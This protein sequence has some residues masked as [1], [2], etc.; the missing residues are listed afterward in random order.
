MNNLKK[1]LLTL[2]LLF[3]FR[4]SPHSLDTTLTGTIASRVITYTPIFGEYDYANGFIEFD[5]GFTCTSDPT[6]YL[7]T[8]IPK[9]GVNASASGTIDLSHGALRLTNDLHLHGNYGIVGSYDHPYGDPGIGFNVKG[10][11]YLGGNTLYLDS[12]FTFT[13][14][15]LC[16]AENGTID[17]Q[18]NQVYLNGGKLQLE[19]S[20]RDQNNPLYLTLK[21]MTIYGAVY[22]NFIQ[23]EPDPYIT[24]GH[25]VLTLENVTFI[26]PTQQNPLTYDNFLQFDP[27]AL[28]ISGDVKFFGDH[29]VVRLALSGGYPYYGGINIMHNSN[30]YAGPSIYLSQYRPSA[31]SL[32]S[33][34]DHTSQLFLDNAIWQPSNPGIDMTG[35]TIHFNGECSIIL[36]SGPTILGGTTASEDMDIIF[37]SG[38]HV[39]VYSTTDSDAGRTL[40]IKNYN[41]VPY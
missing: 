34:E 30:L 5:N 12:D 23:K 29:S 16:F 26:F 31:I 11:I 24:R 6:D 20:N 37:N 4:A 32:W 1:Y 18:G 15:Y 41:S 22:N 39:K 38:S 40:V 13:S 19:F 2:L 10:C 33:F 25:T 28:Y 17:G 3:F 21:N 36:D 14:G 7:G 35:G 27:K 8:N 9:I